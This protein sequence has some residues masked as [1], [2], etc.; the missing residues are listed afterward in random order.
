PSTAPAGDVWLWGNV[1]IARRA[2]P[3]RPTG[4]PVVAFRCARTPFGAG[5]AAEGWTTPLSPIRRY[6]L[7]GPRPLLLLVAGCCNRPRQPRFSVV[8]SRLT[9]FI[10]DGAQVLLA[11]ASSLGIPPS[12]RTPGGPF[13]IAE[14][15]NLPLVIALGPPLIG[16]FH[17]G[18]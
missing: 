4:S 8:A 14:R 3:T 7:A 13:G 17:V 18:H 15:A 11:S 16:R 2:C 9:A 1:P 6:P 5:R 12:T 10:G